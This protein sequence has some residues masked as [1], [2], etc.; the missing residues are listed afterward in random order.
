MELGKTRGF[1][2]H[3]FFLTSFNRDR[4]PGSG[5]LVARSSQHKPNDDFLLAGGE[6]WAKIRLQR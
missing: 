5:T 2:T 4:R 6:F 3:V 1:P